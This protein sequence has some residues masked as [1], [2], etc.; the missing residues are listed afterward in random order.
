[1]ARSIAAEPGGRQDQWWLCLVIC[2][3]VEERGGKEAAAT[4]PS[5]G[6]RATEEPAEV[7][8][9]HVIVGLATEDATRLHGQQCFAQL[10]TG[11][12]LRK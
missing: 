10:L 8:Q 6:V 4:R 5:D 3:W 11:A 1:M 7:G 9:R 12:C 2:I